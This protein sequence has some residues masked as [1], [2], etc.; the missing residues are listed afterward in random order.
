M[1][2]Y[3]FGVKMVERLKKSSLEIHQYL[4]LYFVVNH[5]KTGD[6]F[7][8]FYFYLFLKVLTNQTVYR[9]IQL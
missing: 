6:L 8:Y 5:N 3:S 9:L 7:I 1:K 4:I 2:F